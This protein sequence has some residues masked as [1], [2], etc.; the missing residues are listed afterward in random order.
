[1][2]TEPGALLGRRDKTLAG[3]CTTGDMLGLGERGRE[4]VGP[5]GQRQGHSLGT[6]KK[7]AGQAALS[8]SLSLASLQGQVLREG[9][10]IL[11]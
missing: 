11:Q 9:H 10:G 6:K 2:L 1:M 4:L 5:C 7:T 8:C 3:L